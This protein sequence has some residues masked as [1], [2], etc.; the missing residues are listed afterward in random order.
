[1]KAGWL[2]QGIWAHHTRRASGIKLWHLD[3]PLGSEDPW[4]GLCCQKS[5]QAVGVEWRKN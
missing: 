3:L 5:T 1:M 2:Q 4:L